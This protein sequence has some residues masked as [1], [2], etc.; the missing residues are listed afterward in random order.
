MM[1]HGIKGYDPETGKGAIGAEFAGTSVTTP[2]EPVFD[3]IEPD[4]SNFSR[5]MIEGNE[6]MFWQ[7]GYYRGYFQLTVTP[8]KLSAHF[9]GKLHR[10]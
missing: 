4:A 6:E 1:W 7:E 10:P 8:E 3:I 2:P 9:Y 5:T